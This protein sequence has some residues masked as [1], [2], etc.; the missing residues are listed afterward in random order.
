MTYI[1]LR[2]GE[3]YDAKEIYDTYNYSA[4]YMFGVDL[5]QLI[6]T[7]ISSVGAG[8]YQELADIYKSKE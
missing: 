8:W 2:A 3:V 4:R 7:G 5:S 6:L 1:K